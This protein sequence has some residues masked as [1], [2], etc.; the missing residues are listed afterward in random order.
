MPCFV[1]RQPIP[2]ACDRRDEQ[3]AK[4]IKGLHT[5]LLD[6]YPN[7]PR[8]ASCGLPESAH[9]ITNGGLSVNCMFVPQTKPV[10]KAQ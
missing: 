1:C 8:C 3:R 5:K 4:I 6:K 2:C 10:A 7:E 9:D